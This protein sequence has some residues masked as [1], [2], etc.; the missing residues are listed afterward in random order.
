M[1]HALIINLA[2]CVTKKPCDRIRH[3]LSGSCD[4]YKDRYGFRCACDDHY[5]WDLHGRQC[6]PGKTLF[7]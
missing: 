5:T 2:E 6:I 3:A 1:F 4:G 7:K